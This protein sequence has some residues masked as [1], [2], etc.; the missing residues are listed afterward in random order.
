LREIG[1]RDT[2]T[3][4][5]AYVNIPEE[6]PHTS[7]DREVRYVVHI[8]LFAALYLA[9]LVLRSFIHPIIF[10][11]VLASLC[12]PLRAFFA[13]RFDGHEN[14]IAGSVVLTVAILIIAPLVLFLFALASEGIISVM[15]IQAW[16]QGGGLETLGV[17]PQLAQLSAWIR[18][19]IPFSEDLNLTEQLLTYSRRAGEFL[20]N[21]SADFAANLLTLVISFMLM[22][23]ILFFLVRDGREMIAGLKAITP[24]R[25]DQNNRIVSHIRKMARA[26]FFGS[27]V[28]AICQGIAGGIGFALVGIPSLFWG[29]AMAVMSLIPIVGTALIWVPAVVYLF[30][31]DRWWS[32]GFLFAWCAVV[33]GLMDNVLRPLLMRG[34][35]ELSP[36]FIFLAVLGGLEYFGLPGLLYGPLII[37]FAA[38]MLYLYKEE[39][40]T[41]PPQQKAIVISRSG[42]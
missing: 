6:K 8:M 10:A 39:F 1:F 14:V 24:F 18:M 12:M 38:A 15:R 19:H 26:V 11:A 34:G 25:E 4:W 28:T 40:P 16:L 7:S 36:F 42:K 29:A 9:Y 23:C 32:A 35:S 21:Q 3:P 2:Q 41:A 37:T 5:S 31:V 27:F 17:H 13:R 33:V 30:I 20:L 22:L